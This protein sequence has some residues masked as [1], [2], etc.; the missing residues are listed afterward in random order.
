MGIGTSRLSNRTT[1]TQD[2]HS[3]VRLE[4]SPEYQPTRI[5][6][7]M[8]YT[9]QPHWS[10]TAT[11]NDNHKNPRKKKSNTQPIIHNVKTIR[12]VLH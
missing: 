7:I 3:R 9:Y 4:K 5:K 12:H 11:H 2:N 8:N 6:N 10:K 1:R